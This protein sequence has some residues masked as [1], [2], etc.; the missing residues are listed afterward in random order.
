M[1]FVLRKKDNQISLL[2]VLHHGLMPFSMWIVVRFVPTGHETFAGMLN[3]FVHII[4]YFY[5]LLA[6][7]S[8]P[9]YQRFLWWKKYVTSL[10]L[11][12]LKFDIL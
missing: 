1:F 8:G 9:Q 10:Q 11:V 5:Y 7:V 4:M 6:A 2:H 3:S 12:T